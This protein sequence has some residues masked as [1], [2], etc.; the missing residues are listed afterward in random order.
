[1]GV[2]ADDDAVILSGFA[3]ARLFK[4]STSQAVLSSVE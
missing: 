1:V 2:R 3:P 4:I